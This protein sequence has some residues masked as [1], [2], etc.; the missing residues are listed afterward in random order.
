[1][2]LTDLFAVAV[3]RVNLGAMDSAFIAS[4][5]KRWGLVLSAKR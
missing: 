3:G 2:A 1:M 5:A 4:T